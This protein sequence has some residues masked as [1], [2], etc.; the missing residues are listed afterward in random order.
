MPALVVADARRR[1]CWPLPVAAASWPGPCPRRARAAAPPAAGAAVKL[2]VAAASRWRCAAPTP[3]A[4]PPPPARAPWRRV[5]AIRCA[6]PASIPS[7][8]RRARRARTRPSGPRMRPRRSVVDRVM[9]R[10][11]PR[12][13]APSSACG[14][15][16]VR[17]GRAVLA[18]VHPPV[19]PA[20]PRHLGL[21]QDGDRQPGAHGRG[22]RARAGSS[23]DRS[24]NIMV[25][26][27]V[28]QDIT[29]SR[30]SAQ[31]HPRWWASWP[32]CSGSRAHRSRPTSPT[33][34]TACTSRSPSSRTRPLSDVL[35]IGEHAS[36]F[37]GVSTVGRH[38]P[39]LSPRARRACRCSGTWAR[40]RA[41]SSQAHQSQGYQL[42][43]LYGQSGLENQYQAD[44]RG[45]PGV[46]KVEVDAHGPGGG[47]P[48][49][50]PA[51]GGRR[52]RD[53]HRLRARADAAAGARRRDRRR[54]RGQVHRRAPPSPSIPRRARC[55]RSCRRRPT[56]RRGGPTG[57]PPPTSTRSRPRARRTTTPSRASTRRGRPSSWPRPR[58]RCRPASSAP[59]YT[60]NDTGAYTIPGCAAGGVGVRDLP[61]Q[62]R[63]GRRPDQRV[64]GPHGVERHLLLQPRASQFW[65]D[66]KA[67]AATARRPSRTPPAQLGY[68]DVTGIDLPD[69]TPLRPGGLAQGGRARA[70]PGPQGLPQQQV[71]HG[72]QPRDG[73]RPG[74]H[75]DHP[76]RAGRR[77]RHLRQRRHPLRPADRRRAWSNAHG[78][79]GADRR[80]QGGRARHALAGR[81]P[82]H[83]RRASRGWCRTP[84]APPR[85]AFAGFPL[86]TL[87]LAGKTGTATTNEQ[88][89]NSWFVG[90]GPVPEPAVPDRG[91]GQGAATASQ[92]AAPVVA[93]GLRLPGG[94]PRGA[95]STWRRPGHD[96]PTAPRPRPPP[97]TTSTTAPGAAT[98]SGP[99]TTHRRERP[100]TSRASAGTG[101]GWRRGR[102]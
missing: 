54:S 31:E 32:R 50:D 15:S 18:H 51:H 59:G 29:L 7:P 26:D 99:T 60:Y 91:G 67:N 2:R 38:Q 62:R 40:S 47:Q 68:G 33:S 16:G 58:P 71:V 66:Y 93:P 61:R 102:L 14:C 28:T 5:C 79:G 98:S 63:R 69:E 87:P 86:S 43:D 46:D 39:H 83:A 34:S 9:R 85:G 23:L 88:Q 65:D 55:W 11:S 77:L 74:R 37:P 30:V 100:A 45:T 13:R 27:Q 56:T 75:G 78:Q 82:G 52:R 1:P 73:L 90:W 94:P 84:R 96:G 72:E 57:S 6:A 80:P 89:P 97:T 35:Y 24:D 3:R 42:G 92:A 25:G 95:R 10:A 8:R 49:R 17:G 101:A 19:V 21:L 53:Q 41:G 22:A 12:R 48:G 81:L 70:R 4:R 20:G 44:L 36:M 64:A 76:H